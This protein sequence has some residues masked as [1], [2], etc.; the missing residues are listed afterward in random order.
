MFK[1]VSQMKVRDERGFTL[2]ELLIVVAIIGILAAIAI[3]GYIGMQERGRKGAVTRS[4]ESTGP[5]ISA[6]MMSAKKVGSIQGTLTEVDTNGNG[7]V[8][9]G[10]DDDNNTLA[11]TPIAKWVAL[12]APGAVLAQSSPWAG[13]T[14]L[15]ASV[16]AADMAACSGALSAAAQITLCFTP[17]DSGLITN[18]FMVAKDNAAIPNLIW[19]KTISTD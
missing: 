4:A 6:W 9:P 1:T 19:S 11:V 7:I 16:A 8:E 14:P 15:Y 10:V 17:A 18:V 13:A 3:P 2:I 12:H 5:E